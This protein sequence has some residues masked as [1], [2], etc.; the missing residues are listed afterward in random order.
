MKRHT[1]FMLTGW[2]VGAGLGCSRTAA[3][4]DP[5]G[6]DDRED[7]PGS[8]H[9][10]Q[11]AGVVQ[12]QLE[13]P[14]KALFAI[15]RD[16][17]DAKS[18]PALIKDLGLDK[19]W[20]GTLTWVDPATQQAKP[21]PIH[22]KLH[23]NTSLIDCEF[24]KLAVSFDEA[25]A[26]L[27]VGTPF[28][29]ERKLVLRTH[30]G[31]H[32]VDFRTEGYGRM[33][34]EI[35][36]RREAFAYKALEVLGIPT[37]KVRLARVHYLDGANI[38]VTRDAFFLEDTAEMAA[39][40]SGTFVDPA[41]TVPWSP[42]PHK[43]IGDDAM[44]RVALAEWFLGNMD[45]NIDS[46]GMAGP[47]DDTASSNF[48]VVDKTPTEQLLIPYDFDIAMYVIGPQGEDVYDIAS[49][50]EQYGNERVMA[51]LSALKAGQPAVLEALAGYPFGADQDGVAGIKAVIAGFFQ[52]AE[53]A[54]TP[55][56]P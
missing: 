44:A 10:Y 30:C 32:P 20:R 28:E 4:T 29:G 14:L 54:L 56:S 18:N 45:W 53:A 41:K 38:D 23:G 27:Q 25:N 42:D 17:Y 16:T 51:Q 34:N 21:M 39:R 12:L 31:D 40:F 26:A 36:V 52:A 50:I 24:P 48:E 19:D 13:G 6:L 35:S 22:V 43:T 15:A 1:L 8:G 9:L 49:I 2:L 11:E 7:K 5:Q 46:T 55:P 3:P 47:K 33:A 37:H